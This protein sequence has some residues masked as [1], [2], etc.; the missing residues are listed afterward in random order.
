MPRQP[1]AT[2]DHMKNIIACELAIALLQEVQDA[3]QHVCTSNLEPTI[4]LATPSSLTYFQNVKKNKINVSSSQNTSTRTM[5]KMY[6]RRSPGRKQ[7]QELLPA[8]RNYLL[9]QRLP[10]R[11]AACSRGV[12]GGGFILI[13]Y[14]NCVKY[15]GDADDSRKVTRGTAR[16]D[17]ELFMW[18]YL[19]QGFIY[20]PD[21]Q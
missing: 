2:E 20:V 1:R 14:P 5:H 12:R 10:D 6:L 3:L 16:F 17:F 15:S 7:D 19:R 9:A 13:W 11:H 21:S 8:K 18:N 4:S